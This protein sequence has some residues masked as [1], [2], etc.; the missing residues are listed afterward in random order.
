MRG[1]SVILSRAL[2][3]TLLPLMVSGCVAPQPNPHDLPTLR[4]RHIRLDFSPDGDLTKPVWEEAKPVRLER[5]SRTAQPRVDLST[6][7]RALWTDRFLYLSFDC[8]FTQ[9][10]VFDPVQADER[11]GLWERDVVEAFIASDPNDM[12]RYTEYEVSP[13][14]ERLDVRIPEKDFAWSS[15]FQSGT[16]VSEESKR[17]SAE[18]KIPFA[19]LGGRPKSGSWWR[20]NLYRC[21]YAN[22]AFLAFR[23]TLTGTF[24]T[25]D[26]FGVLSFDP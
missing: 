13:T 7:V 18:M 3:L 25:P 17:W 14:N 9:L 19:A 20:I 23:P 10:T 1:R 24:H 22:K 26:R 2:L 6:T 15:G 8:P 21:D 11:F 5:E 4:A 16:R 12:D